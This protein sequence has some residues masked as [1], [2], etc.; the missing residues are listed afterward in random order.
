MAPRREQVTVGRW[1]REGSDSPP[2][3]GTSDVGR[4][5]AVGGGG[6]HGFTT[7]EGT[8]FVFSYGPGIY[9][10]QPACRVWHRRPLNH[11]SPPTVSRSTP[12]EIAGPICHS[13]FLVNIQLRSLK[14]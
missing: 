1:H 10:N 3:K 9:P 6:S 4:E 12:P 5:E 11:H 13:R 8:T 7:G 2:D 14:N